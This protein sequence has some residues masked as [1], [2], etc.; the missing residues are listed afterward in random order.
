[1]A[2]SGGARRG[3]ALRLPRSDGATPECRG[4]PLV[5]HPELAQDNRDAEL[6]IPGSPVV[7]RISAGVAIGVGAWLV[8]LGLGRAEF[9][10]TIEL[11]TY[12][13]RMRAAVAAR[14]RAERTSSLSKSMK[15]RFAGWMAKSWRAVGRGRAPCTQA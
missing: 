3:A 12:R 1:M 6:M 10:G 7:R 14:N 4:A 8:A 9:L 11:K 13:L 5:M 15:V 2:G